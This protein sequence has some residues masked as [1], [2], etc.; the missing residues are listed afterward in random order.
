[1]GPEGEKHVVQAVRNFTGSKQMRDLTVATV[2][3]YYVIVGQIP[4]LVHNCDLHRQDTRAPEE[5]FRTGFEPKGTNLDIRAH[6]DGAPNSGY[7]AT[8]RSAAVAKLR[9]MTNGGYVYL[10]RGV[11]GV[12]VNNAVPDNIY[13]YEQEIAVPGKIDTSCIVGCTLPNGKWVSNPNYG[14]R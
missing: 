8:T 6:A 4:V 13:A 1:V 9:M 12:D 11:D 10:I 7:V 2:H 14:R 3:T 5:V